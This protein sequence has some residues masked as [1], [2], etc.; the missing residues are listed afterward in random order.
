MNVD[1]ESE[2]EIARARAEVAAYAADPDKATEWYRE[3]R[4]RRVALS[5]AAC[6][7]TQP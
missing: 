7:R 1:V 5:A 6:G 3:H 2:I 4:G